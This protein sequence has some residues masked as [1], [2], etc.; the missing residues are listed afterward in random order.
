VEAVESG[1]SGKS[2]TGEIVTF[3]HWGERVH[4]TTPTTAVPLA[5]IQAASSASG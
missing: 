2:A 4:V 3:T 5:A 1:G